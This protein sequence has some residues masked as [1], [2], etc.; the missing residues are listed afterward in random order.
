MRQVH[1]QWPRIS[2]LFISC[3]L[4]PAPV[5]WTLRKHP[6]VVS[7]G[8]I[9]WLRDATGDLS[10]AS[11]LEHVALWS[12]KDGGASRPHV[13]LHP[14]TTQNWYKGKDKTLE[15]L[16]VTL[17]TE[18]AFLGLLPF[19]HFCPSPLFEHHQCSSLTARA[20]GAKDTAFPHR[21]VVS[22]GVRRSLEGMG[23]QC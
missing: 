18:N 12:L 7:V 14:G 22:F 9:W 16:F 11:P 23:C 1:T 17:T 4:P 2:C 10:S 13:H 21:T 15:G 19:W 6:A 5:W 3:L 20:F 8:L